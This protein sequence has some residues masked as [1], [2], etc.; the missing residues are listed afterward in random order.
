MTNTIYSDKM[1][2]TLIYMRSYE[3]YHSVCSGLDRKLNLRLYAY[4][5]G[6]SGGVPVSVRHQ[7][8]LRS[9]WCLIFLPENEERREEWTKKHGQGR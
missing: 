6:K 5:M 1:Y 3:P 9:F 8:F 4:H 2:L 7:K